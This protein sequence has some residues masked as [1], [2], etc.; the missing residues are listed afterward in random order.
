MGVR[1]GGIAMGVGV[2]EG[3]TAMGVGGE[4]GTAMGVGA[5]VTGAP[6]GLGVPHPTSC[7]AGLGLP[8]AGTATAG[9]SASTRTKASQCECKVAGCC[10]AASLCL[11][12]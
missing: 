7:L 12:F 10:T 2:G 4:G 6:L 5:T 9:Q 3:G 11:H 8:R 1:V